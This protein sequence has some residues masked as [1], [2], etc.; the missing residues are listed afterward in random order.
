MFDLFGTIQSSQ[1]SLDFPVALTE[2][3]RPHSIAEFIGLM[4]LE[5]ELMLA[6]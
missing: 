4:R 6:A 1:S 3:Y 2:R 5:T